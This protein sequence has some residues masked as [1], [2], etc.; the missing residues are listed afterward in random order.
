MTQSSGSGG[1]AVVIGLDGTPYSFLKK[2]V[3]AG[4]LPHL[5]RLFSAGNLGRM[6]T[7]IPTI[8]SVAWASFMTGKNPGDHGIFGFT[9]RWPGTWQLYFP[10]Y[11]HL[12]C[13]AVWETLSRQGKRCCVINVPST[14]PA[15]ELNGVLV[16]GFVA[17]TLEKAV[18]PASTFEYLNRI[19]YRVDVDA[20]RGRESLDALLEDL[21]LTLEKRRQAILKLWDQEPWDLFVAVITET[22]RLHHFMWRYYEEQDPV[23]SSEFLSFYRA[24][25][26]FAG[27]L[28]EMVPDESALFMLSDH[29]SCTIEKEV[30]INAFLKEKGYLA[31]KGESP[32]T[33]ADLDPQKTR[34]YCMDPGRI[35][36]NLEG[37]EPGG[38][39]GP[40]D[41]AGL[42]EEIIKDMQDLMDPDSG[43]PVVGRIIGR[44]EIYA[45]PEVGRGPDFIAHPR[46]GYD[47]KGAIARQE[48]FWKGHLNGMH[49]QDDAFVFVKTPWEAHA[50]GHIRDIATLIRK[51]FSGGRDNTVE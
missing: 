30:Y 2:E 43:E 35:Y 4:N 23:Y 31:L 1:R 14:Y 10:N 22:D 26:E 13:E 18:Y 38:I 24:V 3:S 8:S 39:I 17:P 9:D 16:S 20:A 40:E 45:G 15:R 51:A 37:R 7:E 36:L 32:M 48:I 46:P 50:P 28:A 49:T 25:D 27:E 34:A 21:F 6:E 41:G 12:K 19:G 44:D 42:R 33:I 11:Q 29:G 5:A 47:F